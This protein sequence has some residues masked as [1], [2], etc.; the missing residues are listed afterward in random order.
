MRSALLLAVVVL[1]LL[2]AACG[3]ASAAGHTPIAFGI[4]G[5]NLAPYRVT[6]Q[7]NGSV[8]IRGAGLTSRR[9][10]TPARVRNLQREIQQAHLASRRCAGVLPDVASQYIR[11]G[12]RR[13]TVH[14]TCDQRFQSVWNDLLRGVALLR[15]G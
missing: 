1:A 4:T 8:R 5:G 10:I 3:G 15:T 12:G 6:I 7:P 13:V 2:A 9:H 11:L 14:G